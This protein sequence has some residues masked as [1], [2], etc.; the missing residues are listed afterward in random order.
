MTSVFATTTVTQGGRVRLR[1][2]PASDDRLHQISLRWELAAAIIMDDPKRLRRVAY[3]VEWEAL[4]RSARSDVHAK[5]EEDFQLSDFS[6]AFV[7][8]SKAHQRC[9]SSCPT[10]VV[11]GSS[12]VCGVTWLTANVRHV[13]NC[14]LTIKVPM[15]T[16]KPV[17]MGDFAFFPG[18]QAIS[19]WTFVPPVTAI[20]SGYFPEIAR[21]LDTSA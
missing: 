14:E 18:T 15:N 4:V 2:M 3:D 20:R 5:E 10:L 19:H 12:N 21:A 6:A 16:S 17:P 8:P 7:L 11:R 1:L 9:P 13:W